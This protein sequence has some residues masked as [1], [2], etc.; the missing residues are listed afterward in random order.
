MPPGPQSNYVRSPLKNLQGAH[1][2]IHDVPD[3]E[4]KAATAMHPCLR[5]AEIVS[6]VIGFLSGDKRALC[7]LARTCRIMPGPALLKIEVARARD[8]AQRVCPGREVG[9]RRAIA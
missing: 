9:A 4:L 2:K 8:D 1:R 3:G 7:R 6:V 5:L